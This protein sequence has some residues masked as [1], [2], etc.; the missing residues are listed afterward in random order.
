[1]RV[2]RGQDEGRLRSGKGQAK[3]WMR[4][5]WGQAEGRMDV[6]NVWPNVSTHHPHTL[7]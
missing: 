4:A 3:G 7:G 1:M 2:G 5:V 6:R